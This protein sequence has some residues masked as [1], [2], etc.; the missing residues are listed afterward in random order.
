[1]S[2]IPLITAA[3]LRRLGACED[4]V[5]IFAATFRRGLCPASTH[6][7]RDRQAR[8][9]VAAG[10]NVGWA[11]ARMLTPADRVEFD[12]NCA[13]AWAEYGRV[14]D[15]ALAENKRVRAALAECD[16]AWADAWGEY[17]KICTTTMAEYNRIRAGEVLAAVRRQAPTPAPVRLD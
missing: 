1:M 10:L 3:R 7:G 11:A 15:A 9:I 2:T 8:R 17:D 16:L 12:Q 5:A 14:S 13:F 4:Q 6:A